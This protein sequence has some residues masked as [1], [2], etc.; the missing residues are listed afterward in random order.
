MH[1]NEIRQH[2][3]A[4]PFRPFSIH[5]ADGRCIPVIARDFILISPT[6]RYVNVYQPDETHDILDALFIT[7]VSFAPADSPLNSPT[8]STEP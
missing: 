3:M 7:G 6:G 2:I 8:P 5:M 1:T 4:Q